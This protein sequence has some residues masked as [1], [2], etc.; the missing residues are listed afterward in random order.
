MICKPGSTASKFSFVTRPYIVAG[1]Q[2]A[3][4]DFFDTIRQQL[5][6]LYDQLVQMRIR[7]GD[8]IITFNYDL[9][10]ERSFRSASL[11][12]MEMDTRFQSPK[13]TNLGPRF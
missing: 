3:I 4:R 9:G 12:D 5:A 6:T 11:W 2:E 10:V 1:L 13:R 7:D 8:V